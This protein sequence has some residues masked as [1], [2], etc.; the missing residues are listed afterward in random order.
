VVR[1]AQINQCTQPSTSAM[2]AAAGWPG[3]L[4]N[5]PTGL[6]SA[7]LRPWVAAPRCPWL[8]GRGNAPVAGIPAAAVAA[9]EDLSYPASL[10][11]APTPRFGGRIT[12]SLFTITDLRVHH[13]DPGVHHERSGCS[14][15]TDP[16][17][18]VLAV[19]EERQKARRKEAHRTAKEEKE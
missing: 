16:C 10:T 18:H 15:C 11:Q 12:P 7:G 1:I 17:V 5:E 4:R 13:P 14:R 19:F 6:D 2:A 8:P 9:D 3:I